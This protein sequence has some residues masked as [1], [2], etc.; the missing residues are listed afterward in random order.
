MAARRAENEKEMEPGTP[1]SVMGLRVGSESSS[2]GSLM[3]SNRGAAGLHGY[4]D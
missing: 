1:P 3:I 2:Q 4:Q